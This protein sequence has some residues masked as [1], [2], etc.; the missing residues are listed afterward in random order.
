MQDIP[1][2]IENGRTFV[3][4]TDYSEALGFRAQ[5]DEKRRIP[6]INK[7]DEIYG[8]HLDTVDATQLLTCQEDIALLRE[9]V[10]WEARG[11]DER[12]QIMVANVIFNRMAN[13]G[14][15]L[16]EVIFHPGAFTVV[17]LPQFG[18]AVP[19]A[20]TVDA[21]NAAL[22]GRDYSDGATFFHSITGIQR[23]EADGREVWHE[24]AANAGR[25]VR[26]HDHGNHRFYREA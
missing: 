6:A 1:G 15:S 25:L 4:L 7:A 13:S 22:N 11:E 12:G 20:R 18:T 17:T 23:A 14:Q 9:V 2:Y 8:E 19:N 3:R 24:S 26:L 10:H 21:V 5:W 16:R